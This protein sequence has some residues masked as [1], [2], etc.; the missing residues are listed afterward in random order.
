MIAPVSPDLPIQFIDVRDQAEWIV[1]MIERNKTGTYN[2]TGFNYE[3]TM[4]ELVRACRTTTLS[5]AEFVWISEEFMRQNRM[6]PWSDMPLYVPSDMSGFYRFSNAKAI[7]DGL[8]FRPIQDTIQAIVKWQKT[9]PFNYKMRNGLT[10]ARERQ[11]LALW[12]AFQ[13][14]SIAH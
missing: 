5:D 8:T 10:A 11:L 14:R 12:Y 3:M 7:H 4:G 1:R 2:V 13:Q 6:S 9:R